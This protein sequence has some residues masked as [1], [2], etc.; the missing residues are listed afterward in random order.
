MYNF[1]KKLIIFAP[2]FCSIFVFL[3]FAKQ[4]NHGFIIVFMAISSVVAVAFYYA[5][6]FT[7]SDSMA[8][9]YKGITVL[10]EDS[11][12]TCSCGASANMYVVE[13][14]DNDEDIGI[15]IQCTSDKC[16][17]LVHGSSASQAERGWI[18]LCGS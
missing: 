5:I 15:I 16:S 6:A 2:A 3:M 4:D 7:I 18:A 11:S 14:M 8:K 10:L 17:K 12:F 9:R 13:S 1:L